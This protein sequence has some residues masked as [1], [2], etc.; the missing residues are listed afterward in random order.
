MDFLPNH[1]NTNSYQRSAGVKTTLFFKSF[2]FLAWVSMP[3]RPKDEVKGPE[4]DEGHS[5]VI[6]IFD[7]SYPSMMK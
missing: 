5:S 4:G 7:F 2:Q 6:I 3:E 1:G